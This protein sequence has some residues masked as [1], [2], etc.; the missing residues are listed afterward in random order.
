MRSS[1]FARGSQFRGLAL[2]LGLLLTVSCA[3]QEGTRTLAPPTDA[4]TRLLSEAH[5][6]F[7]DVA[8][9]KN[10]D[11]IPALA[12]VDSDLFGISL[13]TVD[14][15]SHDVGDSDARFSIQSISKVFTLAMAMQEHG[16]EAIREKIGVNATGRVFNS[17]HAIE[18]NPERSV[19]SCVNAGAIATTSLIGGKDADEKWEKIRTALGR[20][21]GREL[22]LDAGSLPHEP[23]DDAELRPG[24]LGQVRLVEVEGDR[25]LAREPRA[26]LVHALLTD[27]EI[28]RGLGRDLD[29]EPIVLCE[30]L[31]DALL[32]GGSGR[33]VTE[34]YVRGRPVYARP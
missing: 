18:D 7:E 9:G 31:V 21:A 15:A 11:Y 28:D 26:I 8:E 32:V 23:D 20:F 16:A 13:V 22:T 12:E 4:T 19:N 1:G 29:V 14:G 3:A 2:L 6:R 33:D 30:L 10:A 27:F 25:V 17:I 5:D 24:R 34:V